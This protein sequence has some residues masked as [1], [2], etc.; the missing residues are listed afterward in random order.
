[1]R[2]TTSTTAPERATADVLAVAVGK[3]VAPDRRGRG[4]R[5]RAGRH[6]DPARRCGRDPRREGPGHGGPRRRRRAGQAGRGRRA[7]QDARPAEVRLAAAAAVRAAGGARAKSVAFALDGV[8]LDAGRGDPVRGRRGRARRLPLH[9]LPH[10]ACRR[11]AGRGGL[12]GGAGRRPGAGPP[13]GRPHRGHQPG[14]RPPEHAG[15]RHG[16]AGAGRA[17]P[18]AGQAA[19]HAHRARARPGV[20]GAA[21]DGPLPGRGP[22]VVEAA[23]H[24]RPS[25]QAAQGEGR[26]RPRPRR[27]GAHVRLGR[28]HAEAGAGPDRDEVRHVGR[29]GG[30]RDDRRHRRARASRSRWS[31]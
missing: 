9:P 13:L 24:D 18:R 26:R 25:P 14:P 15:A 10:R 2:I 19:P 30:A 20:D 11:P 21:R 16:A 6:A 22:G 28:L 17:R 31:R 8:P 3:P 7:R 1:M 12:A 5:P 27:Q 4:R 23:A 29:G